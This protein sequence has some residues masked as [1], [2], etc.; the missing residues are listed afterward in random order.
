M[1]AASVTTNNWWALVSGGVAAIIFGVIAVFWPGL[2]LL[3]LL[4]L[5]S[6]WVLISGLVDVMRGLSTVSMTESWFLAVVLGAFEVG[7]GVYLLRH[8]AVKFSTFVILIGV[9]L[10]AR[11]VI[12]AV[13]SYF[14]SLVTTKDRALMYLNGLAGLVA[15]IVILFAKA[16]QGVAF[17]WILGSYAI[18]VGILQVATLSNKTLK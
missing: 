18:V 14:N 5:F 16:R 3:V 13:E 12:E 8:T 6:A 15:G 17:V 1:S 4:Y 7:V 11:G 10:I 9:T 2:T